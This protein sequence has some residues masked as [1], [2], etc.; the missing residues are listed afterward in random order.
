MKKIFAI[1]LACAMFLSLLASCGTMQAGMVD[2]EAYPQDVIYDDV[3]APVIGYVPTTGENELRTELGDNP[4]EYDGSLDWTD[5][6]WYLERVGDP[7][8][9]SQNKDSDEDGFTDSYATTRTVKVQRKAADGNVYTINTA[10][11]FM[12]FL[13]IRKV[14]KGATFFSEKKVE[15]KNN[16]N[17]V[18]VDNNITVK[19]VISDNSTFYFENVTIKLA[20]DVVIN[21]LAE[22]VTKV[23]DV[24]DFKTTNQTPVINA[25][26][27]FK[28]TFDGQRHVISG[29]YFSCKDS[30]ERALFGPISG[31]TVNVLNLSVVDSLV[32]TATAAANNVGVLFAVVSGTTNITFENV[33]VDDIHLGGMTALQGL[34]AVYANQQAKQN[35]W[36]LHPAKSPSAM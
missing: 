5:F 28:G 36:N 33:Y 2:L 34:D 20:T 11:E 22:G 31:G 15:K 27:Y 6:A 13:Q 16:E 25:A 14:N 12:A 7:V 4:S 3:A 17:D 1:L 24:A 35:S 10:N 18:L 23:E 21:Q 32:V 26:A 29:V 19:Y 30:G 8:D 9:T